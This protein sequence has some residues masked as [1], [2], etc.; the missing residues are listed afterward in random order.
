MDTTEERESSCRT[1]T[2]DNKSK[3]SGAGSDAEG[4]R[5]ESNNNSSRSATAEH[6]SCS[7]RNDNWSDRLSR[8]RNDHLKYVKD[9]ARRRFE[10]MIGDIYVQKSNYRLAVR[11]SWPPTTVVESLLYLELQR[12]NNEDPSTYNSLIPLVTTELLICSSLI[13]GEYDPQELL[14][15]MNP[16]H[17]NPHVN[18]FRPTNS[19]ESFKASSFSHRLIYF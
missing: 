12:L 15:W 18:A 17:D 7:S 3:R 16:M 13:E 11:K 14:L 2:R 10:F 19:A 5:G 9:N 4:E 6:A 1:K 8:G